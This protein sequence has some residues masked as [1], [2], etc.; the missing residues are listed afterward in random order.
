MA[1]EQEMST[2]RSRGKSKGGLQRSRSASKGLPHVRGEQSNE[3]INIIR[4]RA[5]SQGEAQT[6]EL[7]QVSDEEWDD[8][9]EEPIIQCTSDLADEGV[10]HV[11]KHGGQTPAGSFRGS[12]RVDDKAYDLIIGQDLVQMTWADQEHSSTFRKKNAWSTKAHSKCLFP[13]HINDV[14]YYAFDKGKR[15]KF[16]MACCAFRCP[17][18]SP[19]RIA[20]CKCT[21]PQCKGRRLIAP[22]QVEPC[23]CELPK[24]SLCA[25]LNPVTAT[26][27]T[28]LLC[29]CFY[30][31]YTAMIT[32]VNTGTFVMLPAVKML[33][34]C[35]A[36]LTFL[37]VCEMI[38][39]RNL[40]IAE[41]ETIKRAREDPAMNEVWH[42]MIDAE[43]NR[44]Y[45][46]NPETQ[47][48]QWEPPL[49]PTPT[50]PGEITKRVWVQ[51]TEQES[52]IPYFHD[53]LTGET[54]WVDP[55]TRNRRR[56]F[57]PNPFGNEEKFFP[58]KSH[59]PPAHA[60]VSKQQIQVTTESSDN[61][62][63]PGG[64]KMS[65]LMRNKLS[66]KALEEN[67][68]DHHRAMVATC[69]VFCWHLIFVL[70]IGGATLG[71]PYNW[72]GKSV[73]VPGGRRLDA[74][75]ETCIGGVPNP[76]AIQQGKLW[77]DPAYWNMAQ[78]KQVKAAPYWTCGPEKKKEPKAEPRPDPCVRSDTQSITAK[79][80]C[81]SN[82]CSANRYCWDASHGNDDCHAGAFV[83]PSACSRSDV[84]P[85][86][87]AACKCGN[88]PAVCSTGTFCYTDLD[89]C[90]P[91]KKCSRKDDAPVGAA[92]NCGSDKT[93]CS[94]SQYCY[95]T[96]TPNGCKNNVY[97]P[98]CTKSDTNPVGNTCMCGSQQCGSSQ[99]CWSS[100][101]TACRDSKYVPPCSPRSDTS[102]VSTQCKCGGQSLCASG[103]YCWAQEHGN[104][105]CHTGQYVHTPAAS[106]TPAPTAPAPAQPEWYC[107]K[108]DAKDMATDPFSHLWRAENKCGHCN[109]RFMSPWVWV[110]IALLIEMLGMCVIAWMT[111][112]KERLGR[113]TK[114]RYV[115]RRTIA[116]PVYE[117]GYVKSGSFQKPKLLKKV[118]ITKG[119]FRP[120][121]FRYIEPKTVSLAKLV[122]TDREKRQWVMYLNQ[123]DALE[124]VKAMFRFQNQG[125]RQKYSSHS[126][127]VKL[128]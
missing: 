76:Y 52:G 58:A 99:F 102:P 34:W 47:T 55:S 64:K 80:M 36:A 100:D 106:P 42:C 73:D 59:A 101:P 90:M 77:C 8:E 17:Q 23:Q 41:R 91:R 85:I 38:T 49:S 51:R 19:P 117:K 9:D 65:T 27:Y 12:L 25:G 4:E 48:R 20:C 71:T 75:N 33:A 11:V 98:Q 60:P 81:G 92:C 21:M 45:F 78:G 93:A 118:E 32:G 2:V 123:T 112:Q 122:F 110:M 28:A 89:D 44:E 109:G 79:C 29:Y 70:L 125:V 88:H 13:E 24:C 43:S 1:S 87:G 53:A 104:N 96:G 35:I 10:K 7:D 63:E 94:N 16:D 116:P 121:R 119:E 67:I 68:R 97:R 22:K 69:S 74:I 37:M 127:G 57:N 124:A 50:T 15:G 14:D 46:F 39:V 26:L 18:I 40:H 107:P 111:K 6:D 72:A 108:H 95:S 54:Q 103:Q 82:T 86:S 126:L 113:F 120:G 128:R 114:G 56:T 31:W 5:R 83:T 3:V 115:R 105:N 61:G 62:V 66:V 30:L 84:N